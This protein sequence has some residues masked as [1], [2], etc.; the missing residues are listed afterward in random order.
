MNII[1]ITPNQR[2]IVT[3]RMSDGSDRQVRHI[4]EYHV[5]VEDGGTQ[6]EA[7][8]ADGSEQAIADAFAAG[9]FVEVPIPPEQ[10]RI[11]ALE[12]ENIT[13]KL[14][15]ADLAETQ[16]AEKL[17]TQLALAELAELVAGGE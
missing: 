1:S 8:L 14:A 12:A 17:A 11:E 16:E 13:L 6:Y 3:G 10:Q 2:I 7:T 4:N 5:I 9:A 15:L